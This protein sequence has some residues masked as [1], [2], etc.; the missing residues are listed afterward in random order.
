MPPKLGILAGGGSIPKHLI[1]ACENQHRPCFVVAIENNADLE[2][3]SSA[4]HCCV[5]LGS[6]GKIIDSLKKHTIQALNM[7][8]VELV[9]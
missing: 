9:L 8:P 3:I 5:G 4:A 2:S 1:D 6:I 7:T